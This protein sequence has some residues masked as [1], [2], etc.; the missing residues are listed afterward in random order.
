MLHLYDERDFLCISKHISE[1]LWLSK[2]SKQIGKCFQ[3]HNF[4]EARFMILA[5]ISKMH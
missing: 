3:S 1:L 4:L 5:T 2:L